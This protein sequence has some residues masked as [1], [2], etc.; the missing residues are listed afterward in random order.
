MRPSIITLILATILTGQVKSQDNVGL[1]KSAIQEFFFDLPTD[2]SLD[3]LDHL[4]SNN[5]NFKRGR[6]KT[7]DPKV[8][9]DGRIVQDKN[10][11]PDADYN[12]LLVSVYGNRN[13]ASDTLRFGW[14]ITY[15]RN[16]LDI[17]TKDRDDLVTKF[18][19]LFSDR[20]E[21]TGQGYHGEID[22][23]LLLR[24]GTKELE[25]RLTKYERTGN[26]RISI[27]YTEIRE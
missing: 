6:S 26:H 9:I 20:S 10:L 18:E 2:V 24:T 1:L 22:E 14:Y 19:P 27:A 11:N 21:N 4:L 3:S 7:Y 23:R 25:I 8:T 12:Q 15:G 16:E 13:L 5:K 17:V